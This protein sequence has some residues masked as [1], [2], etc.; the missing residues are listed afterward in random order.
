MRSNSIFLICFLVWACGTPPIRVEYP[1]NYPAPYY[2][3]SKKPLNAEQISLGRKLFYDP[4]LSADSTISCSSCH[5]P[6]NA[7]AHSDH[8]LSHGIRDQ[9]GMR[10]APALMNLA[11]HRTFMWDG[12]IHRLDV[13]ALAPISDAKE[14]GSSIMDVLIKLNRSASYKS[15]FKLAF[16]DSSITSEHL[17]QALAQ[18]QLTFTSFQ[19]K[20]DSVRQHQTTFTEQ[21]QKGYQLF[22]KFCNSCHQEPLFS[23]F[24]FAN[25]GLP[26]DT[27][28]KDEG[29][30]RISLFHTD[31]LKFKIPT[32]RNLSYSFPYMHDG[33]FR[34]LQQV[35]S[36]YV[37]GISTSPTLAPQLTGGIPLSSNDKVDIIAFLLTLN[38]KKF[39]FNENFSYPKNY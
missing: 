34:S 2:D 10:N 7:F 21:E 3:F 5:S 16:R 14:M 9:I 38:D 37:K 31:S 32:L 25:N 39:I 28:L 24:E 20:Y 22:L 6:Y 8:T 18:F 26:I 36:H 19:S 29:R 17:L 15:E 35:L 23:T 12:A 27:T 33:R 30:K 1:K 13:Q 4:I 11:W